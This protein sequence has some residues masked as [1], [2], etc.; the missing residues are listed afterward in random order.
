MSEYNFPAGTYYVGDPCYVIPDV[1]WGDFCDSMMTECIFR[2]QGYPML[3]LYTAYG[4]GTYK[5]RDEKL[6]NIDVDSGTIGLVP[7]E[8]ISHENREHYSKQIVTFENDFIVYLDKGNEHTIV[9]GH[10][11]IPTDPEEECDTCG[12]T[13][14]VC[15]ECWD[16]GE[17]FDPRFGG[18]D[19]DQE[20]E[21]DEDE[22]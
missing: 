7:V 22:Y 13:D 1:H 18:C 15:E 2:I 16:C 6:P 21:D 9:I 14:C 3:G 19:C 8:V 20:D 17:H 10:F 4:D 5:V 11:E 12:E